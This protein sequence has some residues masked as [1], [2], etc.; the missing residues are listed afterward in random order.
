MSSLPLRRT[1]ARP[2]PWAVAGAAIGL[3]CGLVAFAPAAW[4]AGALASATGETVQLRDASG[5]LWDG[6]ARLVLSGGKGSQ[7]ALALP[8]RLAWRMA[9]SWRGLRIGLDA[10]CCTPQP[11]EMQLRPA[12]RGLHIA[13]SDRSSAWPAAL[14]AGLGAP[15]NTVL[16]EGLLQVATRGFSLEWREGR[17]TVAGTVTVDALALSSR[18]STRKPI[19]SYRLVLMGSAD[20]A[21]PALQL[22]TLDG[23]LNLSGSGQWA[24]SHWSFRGEASAAP[25]DEQAL[26]N[27]LNVLGRRQGSRSVISLG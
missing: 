23:S 14:L 20:R 21:P 17:L 3:L 16:P 24:G 5:T 26:G 4:L 18:L 9:P 27:L 19:G 1:Q 7:D 6:T 2:A 22:Q 10:T 8:G 13:F 11:I 15:W 25:G 12:W